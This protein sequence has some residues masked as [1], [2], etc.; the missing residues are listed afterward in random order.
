MSIPDSS[1]FRR[2]IAKLIYDTLM[3]DDG[4]VART[5]ARGFSGLMDRSYI[6]FHHTGMTGG[7]MFKI[8][9]P[10]EKLAAFIERG[11][12]GY[13][14]LICRRHRGTTLLASAHDV[15]LDRIARVLTAKLARLDKQRR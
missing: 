9:E 10:S 5:N 14:L 7:L 12:H 15:A 4:F 8:G 6:H 1:D 2:T 3:R 11:A 13:C